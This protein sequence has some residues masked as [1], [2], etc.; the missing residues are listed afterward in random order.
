[1]AFTRAM[2]NSCR[3]NVH[4]I[5]TYLIWKL[6][7]KRS[8]V[9]WLNASTACLVE[10]VIIKILWRSPCFTAYWVMLSHANISAWLMRWHSRTQHNTTHARD[11]DRR[12]AA[13]VVAGP[14][15]PLRFIS[16]ESLAVIASAWANDS[17][18]RGQ[19]GHRWDTAGIQVGYR[20]HNAT[21]TNGFHVIFWGVP[22]L[23]GVGM[24]ALQMIICVFNFAFSPSVGML[25]FRPGSSSPIHI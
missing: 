21:K 15:A 18:P 16:G 20:L 23:V 5:P 24:F 2:G 3:M 14:W 9:S 7:K 13:C 1:M 17:A 8:A 25:L 22:P 12:R 11:L 10:H 4:R 6:P 19:Q